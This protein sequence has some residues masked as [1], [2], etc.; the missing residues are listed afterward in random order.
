[1]VGTW[2]EAGTRILTPHGVETIVERDLTR[3]KYRTD[4]HRWWNDED[5]HPNTPPLGATDAER[6]AWLDAPEL[7]VVQS[8]PAYCACSCGDDKKCYHLIVVR[9]ARKKS[10]HVRN[11]GCTCGD[12]AEC[13]ALRLPL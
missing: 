7:M 2:H 6:M 4:G 12:K 3:D 11:D 10:T 13:C 1:M 9:G 5:I 8:Y